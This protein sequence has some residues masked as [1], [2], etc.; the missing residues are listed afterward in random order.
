M[1]TI[2]GFQINRPLWS[3]VLSFSLSLFLVLLLSL[4]QH[5]LGTYFLRSWDHYSGPRQ[6]IDN[7][8]PDPPTVIHPLPDQLAAP[9]PPH[10]SVTSG[11][12]TSAERTKV[13]VHLLLFKVLTYFLL[14]RVC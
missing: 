7:H 3:S 6:L 9:P 11:T 12:R 4:N 2:L 5:R 14:V 1:A 8:V 13:S 10:Y